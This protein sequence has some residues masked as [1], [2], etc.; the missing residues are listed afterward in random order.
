LNRH[1]SKL[2]VWRQV[3]RKVLYYTFL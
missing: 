3:I 1:R 2:H